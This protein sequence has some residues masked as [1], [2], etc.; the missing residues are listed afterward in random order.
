MNTVQLQSHL[1][2]PLA[3]TFAFTLAFTLAYTYTYTYTYTYL[4]TMSAIARTIPRV[5]PRAATAQI[6]RAFTTT[7]PQ[8]RLKDNLKTVDRKVSDKLVDGID[9]GGTSH[10][11]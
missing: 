4:N 6:P 5:A 1:Q 3:F 7:V 2:P 11:S 10:V 8:H 9:I